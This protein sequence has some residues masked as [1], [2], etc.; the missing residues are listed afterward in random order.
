MDSPWDSCGLYFFAYPLVNVYITMDTLNS[1]RIIQLFRHILTGQFSMSQTV[2]H[3]QYM[4]E[5]VWLN[6][7]TLSISTEE[8]LLIP[9]H[10]WFKE[11]MHWFLNQQDWLDQHANAWC[12]QMIIDKP[13]C[14]WDID[15]IF[16]VYP[17]AKSIN[18]MLVNYWRMTQEWTSWDSIIDLSM[19]SHVPW[20]LH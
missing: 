15:E 7:M 2:R 13:T 12:S 8:W 3:Y 16:R 20:Y 18:M 6:A 9:C 14:W 1:K 5:D 4:V 17:P 11:L 19:Q 10:L